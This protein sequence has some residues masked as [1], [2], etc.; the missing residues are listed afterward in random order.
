MA[1]LDEIA[2]GIATVLRSAQKPEPLPV[3][4]RGQSPTDIV[5]FVRAVIDS[6]QRNATPLSLVCVASELG[7]KLLKEYGGAQSGYQGVEIKGSSD[8]YDRIVFYRFPTADQ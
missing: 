7:A 2:E 5:F 3:D 8:L 1:R 4:M 6:C